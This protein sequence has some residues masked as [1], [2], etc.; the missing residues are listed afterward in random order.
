[1]EGNFTLKFEKV[2]LLMKNVLTCCP[3][4]IKPGSHEYDAIEPVRLLDVFTIPPAICGGSAHQST[5]K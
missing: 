4:R 5:E 3:K 2:K 1:M